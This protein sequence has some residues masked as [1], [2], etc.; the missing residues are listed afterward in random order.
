[1]LLS[2]FFCPTL[3]PK[4]DFYK[5]PLLAKRNLRGSQSLIFWQKS[6]S[7]GDAGDGKISSRGFEQAGKGIIN[8]AAVEWSRGTVTPRSEGA[9]LWGTERRKFSLCLPPESSAVTVSNRDL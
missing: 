6:V 1:M 7:L 3:L 8:R 4:K 2:I 9:D 5:D